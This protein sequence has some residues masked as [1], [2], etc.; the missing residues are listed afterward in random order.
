MFGSIY[1]GLSGL[2]AYSRGLQ[3]IS[4]NV[5]NL[6]SQGFKGS[7]VSFENVL[8]ANGRSNGGYSDTAG[9]G[10]RNGTSRLDFAQGELRQTDRDLDLAIQGNG[11]MMLMR[12]NDVAYTRT[13]SFEVDKQGFIVLSGTDWRLATLDAAGQPQTL[14]VDTSRTSPPQATTKV[15]FS[16]NLSSSATSAVTVGSIAVYDS[17]GAKHVWQAKFEKDTSATATPGSWTVT[18]TDDQGATI[19]TQTL[20]FL[21]GAVDPS[22]S[23]L[24]FTDAASSTSVAFDFSTGV[25][26]YSGGD[27][28]TLRAAS[29]D[30]YATGTFAT[31]GVND[32]GQVEI[33]YSNEQKQQFGSVAIA[34]FRDTSQLTQ[35][36]GGLFTASE[37]AQRDLLPSGDTRVGQVQSRRLEAS[38][39]DL[40][41]EFS[42]LILV[43]RGFQ[44]SSQIISVT[45]DMIQQLFGIRG[46]G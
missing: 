43:Q 2:A 24:T 19:G 10:V 11:L 35:Q 20:K 5:A 3:Q 39:V 9:N 8:G 31:L 21:G 27:V 6:N 26:S 16:D 18:V 33:G 12:G 44:A 14:S 41:L 37:T 1:I 22:T 36:A 15:V 34:D 30:G 38:N 7:T 17:T 13:G 40:T 4:N 46:Q 25:S 23:T 32:K 42:D 45:N 28:S 29:T